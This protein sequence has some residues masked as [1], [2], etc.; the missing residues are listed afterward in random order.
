MSYDL[1]LIQGYP[2][3]VIDT[4]EILIKNNKLG[5]YIDSRYTEKHE[6]KNNTHLYDYVQ[7]IKKK[8]LKNSPP[9]HKVK[10]DDHLDR[11]YSALGLNTQVCR[12]QGK[13]LK[14]SNEIRVSSILK[15]A[16]LEFLNMIVVHELAHLKIKEHNKEFYSLCDH[17][18]HDYMQKEFDFR[19]YLI[20]K[21][22]F[23]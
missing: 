8:Y 23:L 22:S 1:S 12:V 4:V 19:L 2:Q 3:D 10:F 14:S 7:T 17:M 9:L 13:K 15:D 21:N 18:T 6:I 16:P 5:D 20:H 11:L